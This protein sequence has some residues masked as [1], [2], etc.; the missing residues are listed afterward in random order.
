MMHQVLKRFRSS[1]AST[2]SVRCARRSRELCGYVR[3]ILTLFVNNDM[4]SPVVAAW[5]P[6]TSL[7][8]S[9]HSPHAF[10]TQSMELTYWNGLDV[11]RKDSLLKSNSFEGAHCKSLRRQACR[12][13]VIAMTAHQVS[14]ARRALSIES[15]IKLM[16]SI[17]RHNVLP[18]YYCE[19]R[20]AR[21]ARNVFAQ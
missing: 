17:A 4:N 9:L 7:Y 1:S 3:K 11:T 21:N 13:L 2:L 15:V 14:F 8:A 18:K 12:R 16:S 19:H 20:N 5:L 6:A 10:M